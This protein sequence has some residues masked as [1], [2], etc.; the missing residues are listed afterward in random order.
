LSLAL[1]SQAIEGRIFAEHAIACARIQAE[2]AVAAT[3][4]TV[5]AMKNHRGP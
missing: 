4:A 2:R 1:L 5:A 3:A